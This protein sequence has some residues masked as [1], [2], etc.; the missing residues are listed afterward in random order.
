[1]TAIRWPSVC[2]MA[3]FTQV[4]LR[5]GLP[6]LAYSSR[7]SSPMVLVMVRKVLCERTL[8]NTSGM[9]MAHAR[10]TTHDGLYGQGEMLAVRERSAAAR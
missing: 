9:T 1:M 2:S 10:F 7:N 6:S 5:V 8:Q 4:L 3:C